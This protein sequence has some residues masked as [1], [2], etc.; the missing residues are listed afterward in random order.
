MEKRVGDGPGGF[1]ALFMPSCILGDTGMDIS[2]VFLGCLF[3]MQRIR[4]PWDMLG[5]PLQ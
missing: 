5:A 4:S 1:T 3:I 2:K